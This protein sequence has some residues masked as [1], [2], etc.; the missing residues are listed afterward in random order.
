MRYIGLDIGRITT[1]AI[2]HPT[3]T[4]ESL[5][6]RRPNDLAPLIHS[7][8]IV[9]AEWTG[10]LARSWLDT[11]DQA[12]AITFIYH[13][14][15]S[16]GDR[17]HV[18]E[19]R[20]DDYR[21]ARTLAKLLQQYHEA[22]HFAPHTF[23][24][25]PTMR[26][27][28]DIRA[29]ITKAQRLARLQQ[30]MKQALGP[31]APPEAIQAL[32]LKEQQAWNE[33]HQ[34]IANNP[35]TST[36]AGAILTLYP[37]AHRSACLLAAYIAPLSRFPSFAHLVSYCGLDPRSLKSGRRS[38]TYRYREGSKQARTALFQLVSMVAL[39]NRLRPYYDALRRRGK[40]HHEAILRCMISELRRIW[41]IAIHGASY[42][43]KPPAARLALR[44]L[45]ARLLSLISS[46]YTDS[47]ACRALGIKPSRLSTWKARS[48]AFLEAYINARATALANRNVTNKED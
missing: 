18:G 33:I 16:K 1:C 48:P 12:G 26:P 41:R 15:N 27:M 47:E 6:L 4:V 11:A 21:D 36:I 38:R 7:D 45:Q 30:Q 40:D 3:G 5:T 8:D 20:K 19:P 34:A 42:T 24:P 35:A 31:D 39:T 32:K 22:P 9:A 44:E 28:L 13:P 10:S 37:T 43:P 46:G 14:K 23:T 29:L 25:Y 2:L 17:N